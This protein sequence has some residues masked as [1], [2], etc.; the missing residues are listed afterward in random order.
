MG[1]FAAFKGLS[2]L[3]R[4]GIVLG[5]AVTLFGAASVAYVSWRHEQRMIGYNRAL[6][7]VAE[8]N[9]VAKG[10]ARDIVGQINDCEAKG[11]SWNVSTGDCDF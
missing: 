4:L 1:L 5:L 10:V 3:T 11:G 6:A 7:E 2:L 8:Q 9:A